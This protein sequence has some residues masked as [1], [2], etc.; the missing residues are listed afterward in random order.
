M[1]TTPRYSS[2]IAVLA[3]L[4]LLGGCASKADLEPYA[5][6]ADLD[7]LRNELMGEI[8]KSQ[9]AANAAAASA[10]QAAIDAKV[11]ADKADAIFRKSLR[12]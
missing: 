1:Q 4:A 12:K 8:A 6:K 5:T 7:A 10:Q 3:L 2:K 9:D 11:A